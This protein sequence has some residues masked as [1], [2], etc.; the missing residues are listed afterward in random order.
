MISNFTLYT[1]PNC[2]NCLVLKNKLTSSG[3]PFSI[4]EINFGQEPE[5][6][7]IEVEEFKSQ[8]PGVSQMPFF[9]AIVSGSETKGGIREA[10]KF[11]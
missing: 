5:H 4:I 9:T 8:F 3:I 6:P 7:V 1:K 10:M 11:I 2:P